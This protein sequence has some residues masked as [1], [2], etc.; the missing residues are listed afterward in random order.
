MKVFLTGATGVVGKHMLRRLLTE[1]HTV[2]IL[3]RF[4]EK[5]AQLLAFSQ[6]EMSDWKEKLT[7]ALGDVVSGSGLDQGMQG[8]DAVIPLLAIILHQGNNTFP[9][10]PPLP[11]P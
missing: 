6:S 1:G 3:L 7:V 4:P 5:K 9:A 2:R 11:P 10:L 8:F